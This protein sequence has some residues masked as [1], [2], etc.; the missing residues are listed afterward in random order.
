MSLDQLYFCRPISDCSEYRCP[1]SGL[2]L[3]GSGAHPGLLCFCIYKITVL[4]S[5]LVD[6][7]G[8]GCP[9]VAANCFLLAALQVE[10]AMSCVFD[11]PGRAAHSLTLIGG[12]LAY[13]YSLCNETVRPYSVSIS[14][15]MVM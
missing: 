9:N 13:S 7:D 1:L 8:N 3:C 5:S 14:L 10:T 11:Q 15:Y 12:Q 4:Y 6:P 2:Y